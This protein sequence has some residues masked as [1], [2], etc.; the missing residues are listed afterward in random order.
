MAEL[1]HIVVNENGRPCACGARG[2]LEAESSAAALLKDAG[3]YGQFSS[4]EAVAAAAEKKPVL[5]QLL[6]R[7]AHQMAAALVSAVNLTDVPEVIIG[8]AHFAA[9]EK[10]FMPILRSAMENQVLR[11]HVSPVA[12]RAAN[13][14]EEANAIGAA[15]LVLHERVPHNAAA[16]TYV[17]LD[18]LSVHPNGRAARARRSS[19]ATQSQEATNEPVGIGGRR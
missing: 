2:C 10:I 9:V 18:A 14:G 12:L 6:E 1:G 16:T 11:R 7:A 8:G 19:K 3:K 17:S 13:V 15:A 4:I 5:Q